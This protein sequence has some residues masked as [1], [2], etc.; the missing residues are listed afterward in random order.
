MHT[1]YVATSSC[2]S[3]G[4]A[5]DSSSASVG[6]AAIAASPTLAL[7]LSPADPLE[8]QDDV[9]TYGVCNSARLPRLAPPPPRQP[10]A[11]PPSRNPAALAGTRHIVR[12]P[13]R[14]VGQRHRVTR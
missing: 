6:D 7:E 3:S 10:P 2:G 4:S 5:G 13:S 11:N 1:P 14:P 9:A 12:W 8:P